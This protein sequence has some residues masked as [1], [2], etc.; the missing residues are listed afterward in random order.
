VEL[1]S[2][3]LCDASELVQACTTQFRHFGKRSSFAGSIRTIRVYEDV[4]DLRQLVKQ[5]GR[6]CVLVI[7]AG[8]SVRRAVLGDNMANALL[9]NGWAGAIVNGAVRDTAELDELD[10]GVKAIGTIPKRGDA[11][12]GG[13]IDVPVSFGD[14]VFVPGFRLVAD[15]DGVVVLPE[16]RRDAGS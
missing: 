13:E 6:G 5:P 3:D 4:E 1:K 15:V 10:F 12:G 14:V 7:D 9:R 8:G 11:K 16:E 2:A